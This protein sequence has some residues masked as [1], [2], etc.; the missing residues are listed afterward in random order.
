MRFAR[1]FPRATLAELVSEMPADE[2]TDLFKR[3]DQN[4]RDTLLAALAQA[5]REDIHKLSA[6][7]EGTAGA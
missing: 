4:Q 5:E 7:V 3:F 2:R 1:E 6:Y